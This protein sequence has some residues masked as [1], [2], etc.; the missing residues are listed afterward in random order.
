MAFVEQL[1]S[2]RL[3]LALSGVSPEK[4]KIINLDKQG[5]FGPQEIEVSFNPE[6]I[7]YS[8]CPDYTRDQVPDAVS[9]VRVA[10][11][12]SK[13]ADTITMHLLFDTTPTGKDVR[14]EYINFLI[15]LTKS[16]GNDNKD[17]LQPPRCKFVWGKF[18]KAPYLTFDAVVD[19]L[20]VSYTMFLANGLPIRAECDIT[21]MMLVKEKSGT[22][23]TSRSEARRVWR[24]VEGQ[25][26]DW[27][28]YQEYGDTS[29]WRHIA[30]VN[31]LRNPRDLKPGMV[32]RMVPLP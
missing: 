22:N 8:S 16:D 3:R 27:I 4:A 13:T 20:T 12:G 14:S 24:V 17:P 32:L 2:R 28:A 11:G 1:A 6:E 18:S 31:N 5:L 21:F 15:A 19:K 23:P 29:A 10:Y 7:T 9:G 25:T 26:L 30:K